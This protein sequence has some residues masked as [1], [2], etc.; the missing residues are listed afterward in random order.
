MVDGLKIEYN[1]NEY[2]DL[3]H[4]PYDK[5]D[6][7][8]TCEDYVDDNEDYP[9]SDLD[10]DRQWKVHTCFKDCKELDADDVGDYQHDDRPVCA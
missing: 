4:Y 9:F 5:S 6:D 8:E 7:Y 10:T 2:K 1:E 3:Y